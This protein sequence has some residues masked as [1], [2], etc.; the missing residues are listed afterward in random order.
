MA[1]SEVPHFSVF[2]APWRPLP[3]YGGEQAVLY[4]SEDGTRMSGT[5]RESGTHKMVMPFDEFVYVIGGS[6]TITVEGGNSFTAGPGTAFY[7]RQGMDITW[8]MSD[9]FHD[10]TVLVSDQPIDQ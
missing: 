3:Q 9:D 10:V 1:T 2:D 5:Y 4:R 8:E 7:V 6:V